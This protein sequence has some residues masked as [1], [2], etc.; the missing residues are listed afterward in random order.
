MIDAGYFINSKSEVS[1]INID[2]QLK[3]K[4]KNNTD[5]TDIYS[6]TSIEVLLAI[7]YITK[8]TAIKEYSILVDTGIPINK[9]GYI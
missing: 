9:M 1:L 4:I 2:R 6:L 5:S 7:P 8:G 3:E